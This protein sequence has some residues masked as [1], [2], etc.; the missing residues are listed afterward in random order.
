MTLSLSLCTQRLVQ[1]NKN[2]QILRAIIC[3]PCD[4]II[5]ITTV[6]RLKHFTKITQHASNEQKKNKQ[7]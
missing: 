1:I 7:T 2:L 6:L 3:M 4:M 5:F